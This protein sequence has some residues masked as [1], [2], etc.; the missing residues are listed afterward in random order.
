MA[1]RK[2]QRN[3]QASDTR[4]GAKPLIFISASQADY[5][6]RDRLKG[7]ASERSEVLPV[8]WWDDSWILPGSVW[9]DEIEAAIRR[10]SVAV[11]FLSPAYLSSDNAVSELG[12]LSTEAES[13][14]LRLLPVV[15]EDCAWQQFESLRRI[16]IWSGARPLSNLSPPAL[17]KELTGIANVILEWVSAGSMPPEAARQPEFAFSETA[18]AVLESARRLAVQSQRSIVTSSCLLF[19]LAETA[20]SG[21]DTA[22]FVR[23]I[24]NQNAGY[25]SAFKKFL[26]DGSVAERGETI[27]GVPGKVS[28]N[29][30]AIFNHAATIAEQVSEGSREIHVRHLFAALLV[31]PMIQG[32][33]VARRRL[34]SQGIDLSRV[35][36]DFLAFLRNAGIREDLNQWS[37]ILAPPS[38]SPSPPPTDAAPEKKVPP[39]VPVQPTPAT[40]PSPFVSGS[41]GYTSEFCGVGGS[42]PV[43]DYLGVEDLANR[44][45]E[46][47][48]LRET[49]L[50]LAVGLFGN[51]GSGKSH[52]MNLMDRR[53]KALS[54]K[55]PES[56]SSPQPG[57]VQEDQWCGEIV[58]IY[59]NA[60]HYSDS[61]LWASLVTEVFDA[62][63]RH[64]QPKTDELSLL[65]SRLQEAGGVTALA[66]E[67]ARDASEGV[68]QATE[69][70]EKARVES[71]G[72]KQAMQGLLNGLQTLIPELN[73]PKNRDRIT[74]L[75]GVPTEAATI[76]EL[77]AKRKELNSVV[78]RTR[79]LWRRAIAPEGRAKRFAWL[80]GA[81]AAVALTRLP[82]FHTSQIQALLTWM[83]PR[84]QALL[85]ALS[86]AIAWMIPVFGQV[87]KALDQLEKWQKQAEDAQAAMPKDPEVIKAQEE[88]VRAAARAQGAE[89]ALAEA[90]SRESQ[91]SQAVSDLRPERRLSRF[92]EARA[93]S[94]D[95]RGQL[96]LVSL[97]RR[98]FAEL[99]SIF[100]DYEALQQKIEETP[101][102]AQQLQKLSA[103]VDRVVLF[104]DDLDRCEPEKVVDVLQAVHLLLAYPLF[105]VVVGVDQRC[106]KQSLR[107]RFKGLLTPDNHNHVGR[108]ERLAK[109]DEIPA[110]PL[111]YLEKIFHIPFHLPPMSESGFATLLEK[112]TEPVPAPVNINSPSTKDKESIP[113]A[114]P[115][116]D[117]PID[118]EKSGPSATIPASDTPVAGG[119][120]THGRPDTDRAKPAEAAVRV[121]GSVPLN[122]WERK[123]LK[124]YYSLIGTPRGATR[125]LNTYRLVRAGVP[126]QEW[127]RFRGDEGGLMEFR[128][129]LL[130]LAVAAGQPAVAREWFK[131][132]RLHESGVETLSD[133]A[134]GA[135]GPEWDCFRKLYN[136]TSKQVK[137]PWT[138]KLMTK[139]LDR[140]ERFTF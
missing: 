74:E 90:R 138:Q 136:E 111:D 140:V 66:A 47:M 87:T 15:V 128:V 115:V 88:I 49:K 124:D 133:E 78:G 129:A 41:P 94:E 98:D 51:W 2:P 126:A 42:A 132:L 44:L 99:S 116:P 75:L 110:T 70:L 109:N 96:G 26:T 83:G 10:A 9:K 134:T 7:I 8:D 11:I 123:A 76:S 45:A 112:L 122:P 72:A 102:Q 77:I 16:Q 35:S 54:R 12:R 120:S 71:E 82:A 104:I 127:D 61:N 100:A 21:R 79:E 23:E 89:A 131:Q 65:Q 64:L 1:N 3:T 73:T 55:E 67:E 57:S 103:S 20:S 119:N 91:L 27:E 38:S 137:V 46:L 24:L 50:P 62:L 13:R 106:L 69:A 107:I 52:F 28:S 14:G 68:R 130:L 19:G 85:V 59:F 117:L 17:D 60:W 58:P 43:M 40:A 114:P 33:P 125:L 4:I 25:D 81:L 29:I 32:T 97:A 30:R 34:T 139:W 37:R 80:V 84:V 53:M 18:S 31:A 101:E 39:D 105:G 63:F 108:S 56:M 36:A 135:N 22:G 92:I 95:Y 121:L 118:G 86:A 93:R 48:V 6:W 5:S 113:P